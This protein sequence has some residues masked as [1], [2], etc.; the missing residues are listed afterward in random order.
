MSVT[1]IFA[2]AIAAGVESLGVSSSVH[3]QQMSV[4]MRDILNH[5]SVQGVATSFVGSGRD[6]GICRTVGSPALVACP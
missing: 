4:S 2:Y 3:L 5:F 6:N 1:V